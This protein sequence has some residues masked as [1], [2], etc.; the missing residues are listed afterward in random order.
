MATPMDEK[1]S[2]SDLSSSLQ[3]KGTDQ[4]NNDFK[5]GADRIF[6]LRGSVFLIGVAGLGMLSGFGLTIARA[7]RRSPTQF[8]KG[9][10]P[11]PSADLHESG[12][13]LALKALG[14]GSLFAVSGVGVLIYGACKLIG[15]QNVQEFKERF[16]SVTPAIKRKEADGEDVIAEL[17][18]DIL[19]DR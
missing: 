2:A 3:E 16:Q 19:G 11:D 6:I 10:L 8:A 15:V 12:A 14:W 1:A 17:K 9:V 5:K 13:A 18:S 7:K 4:S